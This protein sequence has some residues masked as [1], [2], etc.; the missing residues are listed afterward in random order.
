MTKV[1]AMP[2]YK[3]SKDAVIEF[4]DDGALV[5]LLHDRRLVELNPSAAAI[6]SLLDGLRTSEQV[7]VEIAKIYDISHDYLITQVIHDVLELCRELN[8]TG[9]LALQSDQ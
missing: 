2:S 4:F 7:A 5:L 8:R 3:I 1:S 9:V 6:V